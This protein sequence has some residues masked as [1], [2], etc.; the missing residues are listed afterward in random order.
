MSR[1]L[2]LHSFVAR[3]RANGPG[4]RAVVWV[5]GC[6]RKCAGCFNPDS[7]PFESKEQVTVDSLFDRI[8]AV[9]GIDGVTISGGEPFAQAEA[10]VEL[11][12]R[13]HERGMSV[14]CYTGYTLEGL[15][16]GQREDWNALLDQID[17]LIDGPFVQSQRCFEPFRGSSNQHFYYLSG[18]ISPEAVQDSVQSV[19]FTLDADGQITTTGFPELLDWDALM[20]EMSEESRSTETPYH[21]VQRGKEGKND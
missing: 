4:E 17:L 21:L 13:L 12:K 2:N 16:L 20:A 5:Q 15:R 19:E 1:T 18:R 9:K 10:L 7:Q 11:A 14:V 6:P 3:S 8:M